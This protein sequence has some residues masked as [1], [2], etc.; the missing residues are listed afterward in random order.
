MQIQCK[1]WMGLV[2][3]TLYWSS[4]LTK[5]INKNINYNITGYYIFLSM[6][7]ISKGKKLKGHLWS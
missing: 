3:N 5:S 1:K 2:Q 6:E 4:Y 7:I